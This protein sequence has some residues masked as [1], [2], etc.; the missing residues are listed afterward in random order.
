LR[1]EPLYVADPNYCQRSNSYGGNEESI[2]AYS[3]L[4]AVK[5][6]IT[7]LLG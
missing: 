7:L 6:D 1:L 2:E 5:F 3:M 4:K